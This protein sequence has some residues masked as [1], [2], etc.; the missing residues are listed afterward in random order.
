MLKRVALRLIE[1]WQT[2]QNRPRGLCLH[3]PTCSAYGH[4]VI[5]ERGFFVGGLMTAW[6]IVRCNG[7]AARASDARHPRSGLG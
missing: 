3:R 6:R 7:C 2:N 1:G 5:S 4:R